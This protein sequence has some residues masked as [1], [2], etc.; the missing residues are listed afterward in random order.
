MDALTNKQRSALMTSIKG[1]DTKPE[2]TVRQICRQLGYRGYR[3]HRKD[4]PGRPD[5]AW[6]GKKAA[7]FVN[8]CFWHWHNCGK[9]RRT[10]ESNAGYWV[11]KLKRNRLRDAGNIKALRSMGWRIAI[12]WECELVNKEYIEEKIHRLLKDAK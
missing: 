2:M 8:G 11:D 3:L 5:M 1:T 6:I 10:P 12:I 4:L 9:G 7:I